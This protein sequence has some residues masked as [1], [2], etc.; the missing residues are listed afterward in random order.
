[1]NTKNSLLT[2]LSARITRKIFVF[3][4][5]QS[6]RRI[7]YTSRGKAKRNQIFSALTSFFSDKEVKL[8][9]CKVADVMYEHKEFFTHHIKRKNNEENFRFREAAVSKAYRVYVERQGKA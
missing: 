1:M 3:A 6:R 9:L 4:K 5:P 8:R 2:T 7:G